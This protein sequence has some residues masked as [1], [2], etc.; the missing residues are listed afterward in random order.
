MSHW[1]PA[2]PTILMKTSHFKLA[3]A[4][5][6]SHMSLSLALC[7]LMGSSFE[8]WGHLAM[9]GDILMIS[10]GGGHLGLS[11]QRPGIVPTTLGPALHSEDL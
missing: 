8:P 2:N 10:A 5:I 11:G 6:D 3:P 4:L 7:F 1:R 9:S